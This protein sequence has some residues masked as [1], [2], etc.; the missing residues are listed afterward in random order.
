MTIKEYCYR[1]AKLLN[2][3]GKTFGQMFGVSSGFLDMLVTGMSEPSFQLL[4]KME[5]E[6]GLP[7]T[8]ISEYFENVRINIQKLKPYKGLPI[9]RKVANEMKIEPNVID[10][11]IFGVKTSITNVI[12]FQKAWQ[13][14]KMDK[15]LPELESKKIL[16]SS[17]Y[18]WIK[19]NFNYL[20][21]DVKTTANG[22]FEFSTIT[23]LYHCTLERLK[24]DIYLF[25]AVYTSTGKT[26]VKL[27]VRIA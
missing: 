4:L 12:L 22:A 24:D 5:D 8:K 21:S 6:C 10:N 14:C 25:S 9:L 13:S 19:I 2:L 7:I 23:G 1:C 18:N 27:V 26:S 20:V 17:A 3:N 16:T 11:V 15:K